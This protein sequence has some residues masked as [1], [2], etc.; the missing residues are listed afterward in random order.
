MFPL[1]GGE[2]G[3]E[4]RGEV[5]GEVKIVGKGVGVSPGYV[6]PPAGGEV[7]SV[8]V[9]PGHVYPPAVADCHWTLPALLR[10]VNS[11]DPTGE[12]LAII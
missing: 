4:V 9:S 2:V 1:V 11:Q 3:G 10:L 7:G 8:G 12:I 5:E 6:Y